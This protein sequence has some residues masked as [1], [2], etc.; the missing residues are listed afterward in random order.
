MKPSWHIHENEIHECN[1][2]LADAQQKCRLQTK[3]PTVNSPLVDNISYEG[4]K[5]LVQDSIS[6]AEEILAN[7]STIV[8]VCPRFFYLP[9]IDFPV[10]QD[11][12]VY[13]LQLRGQ[14][15]RDE[16]LCPTPTLAKELEEVVTEHT[17]WAAPLATPGFEIKHWVQS[18]V[19]ALVVALSPLHLITRR[20][21]HVSL[22]L[23]RQPHTPAVI[24]GGL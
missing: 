20:V 16:H 23:L 14:T 17:L 19:N 3:T 21:P 4:Y 11:S 18:G 13:M 12:L 5:K 2:R 8:C 15:D 10:V 9:V 1:L 24:I 6:M 7:H 22:S